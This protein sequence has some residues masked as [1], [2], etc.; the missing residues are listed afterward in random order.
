M[1][2]AAG[3]SAR[4]SPATRGPRAR[5]GRSSRAGRALR[6]GALPRRP[7]RAGLRRVGAPPRG[8]RCAVPRPCHACSPRTR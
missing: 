2:R 7:C 1:R 8:A 5:A 3:G 4:Q 6:R